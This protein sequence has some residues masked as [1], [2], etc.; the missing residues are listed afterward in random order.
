MLDL[1]VSEAP[2]TRVFLVE[3]PLDPKYISRSSKPSLEP[4][5]LLPSKLSSYG[6]ILVTLMVIPNK[7]PLLLEIYGMIQGNLIA[8]R[9]F[10]LKDT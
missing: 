3:Q 10:T 9:S 6:S 1:L 7:L 5:S 8:F 2:S 4:D